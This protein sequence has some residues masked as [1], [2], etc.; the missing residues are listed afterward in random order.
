MT[1]V[2]VGRVS[3]FVNCSNSKNKQDL[4]AQNVLKFQH[5][6]TMVLSSLQNRRGP[7]HITMTSIRDLEL[8]ADI[9]CD[10]SQT[11]NSFPED[12]DNN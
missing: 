9:E 5:L 11:L 2:H 3:N 7:H 8:Q 1:T 12:L 6:Q 10:R 4:Q